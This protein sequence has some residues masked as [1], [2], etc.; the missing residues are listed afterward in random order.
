LPTVCD[1]NGKFR[2]LL[3]AA[4]PRHGTDGFTS[5]PKEGRLRTF[6]AQKIRRLQPGLNPRTRVPEASNLHILPRCLYVCGYVPFAPLGPHGHPHC[7]NCCLVS[8]ASAS[9]CRQPSVPCTCV[10]ISNCPSSAYPSAYIHTGITAPTRK[11]SHIHTAK[12]SKTCPRQNT[13][14]VQTPISS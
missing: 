9:L 11:K 14:D 8:K 6:F 2:N 7:E 13:C 12:G 4:N 1:F 5:P 3:H 10:S